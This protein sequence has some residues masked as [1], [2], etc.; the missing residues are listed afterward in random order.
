MYQSRSAAATAQADETEAQL[1]AS[2]TNTG[3]SPEEKQRYISESDDRIATLT[4]QANYGLY[5]FVGLWAAGAV[6]AILY[7][8]PGTGRDKP[9]KTIRRRS[10]FVLIPE[11]NGGVELT[12]NWDL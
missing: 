1:E 12:Y 3:I 2:K 5:A 6:Q 11:A 9:K 4:S 8:P 10:G 7:D